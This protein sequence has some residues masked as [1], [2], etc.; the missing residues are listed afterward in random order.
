[1]AEK[2]NVRVNPIQVQKYLKGLKYPVA[3][4]DL[5]KTAKKEGA[6]ENIMS[7]LQRL[8]DQSYEAPTAVT[9]ALGKLE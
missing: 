3:K 8:P 5:I 1:M 9:K 4:Q 2:A 7:A 6:D